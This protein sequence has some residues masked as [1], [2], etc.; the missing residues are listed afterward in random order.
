MNLKDIRIDF[1]V[2]PYVGTE[3]EYIKDAVAVRHKISGDGEYTKR[4]SKWLADKTKATG[5]L[6]TTSCTHA[7]EMAA[8]LAQIKPGDEV[9]M[10]SY[11]FV[12]TADAFVLRGAKIVFVDIRPDTM[13]INEQLIEDAIT[14]KT[15]AIVP[16]HYAGVACEMD[17]IL[18]IAK[19]HGLLVIEDAAQGVMS[20]YK[21]RYLGTL[22]DYGCYSFHETK[23]YSMGEGGAILFRDRDALEAGEIIREKGTDRSRFFRGQIDKYTWVDAGSS[24]LPSEINAAYLYAQLLAAEE[25]C[26]DRMQNWEIYYKLLK[27]LADKNLLDIPYVPKECTHNAHM[28]YIKLKDMDQRTELID[29]LHQFGICT[30]FHYVPLHSSPAGKKYGRFHGEDRY[31]TKESERLLRL[32]MYYGLKEN[33]TIEVCERITTFMRERK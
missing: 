33:E 4:C 27:P 25:I 8:L 30:V 23:N 15:K 26:R 28:F 18:E 24:Y 22:G 20:T 13:N 11:T 32:P 7:L 29:Y 2:P 12:S 14:E 21:D 19:S 10:P 31:T 16:V 5:V 3:T 17:T 6:L 9:I 1:N